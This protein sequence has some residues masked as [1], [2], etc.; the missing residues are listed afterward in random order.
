G[1]SNNSSA[2]VVVNALPTIPVITAAGA[3]TFC[4]G[5]SVQLVSSATGTWSNGVTGDSTAITSSGSYTVLVRDTNGCTATSAPISV[6]V[7]ALPTAPVISGS[8][9]LN[10]CL[11]DTIVLTAN[12]PGVWSTGDS[13][14]SIST[15]VSG[16]YVYTVRDTNGC[17]NNSSAVVV[18]NALPTTP[19]ITAAGSTTICAGDTVRLTSSASGTWSTGFV[20]TTLPVT[21]TGSYFVVVTD[22]NGCRSGSINTNVTVNPVPAKPVITA[23]RDTLNSSAVSGNQWFNVTTGAVAGATNQ[24]LVIPVTGRY[25]AVVT[26]NG[27]S[28]VPSDTLFV[29]KLGAG[30]LAQTEVR[31]YPNPTSGQVY[32]NLPNGATQEVMVQVMDAS[33][34]V[35]RTAQLSNNQNAVEFDLSGMASGLYLVRLNQG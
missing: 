15:S 35:V 22:S 14:L 21:T 20:G 13:T 33:G 1:C 17:S 29:I 5:G 19:V 26:Q 6:T 34:R 2:V 8:R 11:G 25:F 32:V 30:S 24:Q 9:S 12:G 10:M 7:N 27:C 4:Q 23:N 16:S 31:V 18:V 3:T 28:S